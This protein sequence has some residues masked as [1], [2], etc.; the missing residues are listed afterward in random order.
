M[1]TASAP[2]SSRDPRRLR[3]DV[4]PP[5]DQRR[6]PLPQGR[7]EVAQRVEQEGDAVR[8]AERAARTASSRTKSGTTR[9][10]RSAAAARAGWSCTRRSRVKRTI[11]VLRCF[12]ISGQRVGRVSSQSEEEPHGP[13]RAVDRRRRS[14]PDRLQPVDAVRGVPGLHGGDRAG[15]PAGRHASPL[16]RRVRRKREEWDA[17]ITE[18]HPDHR[19][20]W[21]A[22]SG[23]GN[24]GVVT[25]HRIADEQTRVMVQMDW[26]PEGAPSRSAPRWAWTAGACRAISSASRS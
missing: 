17:E 10:A 19:V 24:A 14:R 4:A 15:A 5:D 16:D 23:K 8:C 7:I 2:V 13:H 12:A 1:K 20:A 26:E 11:A 6:T 9:S 22:T 25:F 18:Q 3:D 21:T